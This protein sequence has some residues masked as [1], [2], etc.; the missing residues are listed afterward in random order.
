MLKISWETLFIFNHVVWD[1]CLEPN[2]TKIYLFFNVNFKVIKMGAIKHTETVRYM[3]ITQASKLGV[4]KSLTWMLNQLLPDRLEIRWL[5]KTVE[6]LKFFL[7]LRNFTSVLYSYRMDTKLKQ[8][9]TNSIRIS[10]KCSIEFTIFELRHL[11]LY[12]G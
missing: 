7:L 8:Q 9:I 10:L 4:L 5:C 1:V 3:Y 11:T 2:R 6:K 12:I